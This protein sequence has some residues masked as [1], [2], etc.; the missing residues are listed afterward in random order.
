MPGVP[1]IEVA[2][3]GSL[4]LLLLP[5]ADMLL[6]L[7]NLHKITVTTLLLKLVPAKRFFLCIVPQLS[8]LP[9]QE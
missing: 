8:K 7:F 4:L 2:F 1:D 6:P 3:D 9:P 5:L